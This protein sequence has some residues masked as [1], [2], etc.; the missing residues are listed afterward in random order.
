[1]YMHSMETSVLCIFMHNYAVRFRNRK[2]PVFDHRTLVLK[3][4]TKN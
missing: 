1:M 2:T 3:L 4:S